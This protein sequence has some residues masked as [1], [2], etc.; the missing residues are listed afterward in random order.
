M[1]TLA[2]I[3]LMAGLVIGGV[4]LLP[5]KKKIINKIMMVKLEISPKSLPP[6][7]FTQSKTGK[8]CTY[9]S[10]RALSSWM[11]WVCKRLN[12]SDTVAV[13]FWRYNSAPLKNCYTELKVNAIT[14]TKNAINNKMATVRASHLGNENLCRKNSAICTKMV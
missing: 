6:K 4:F 2:N 5:N 10:M 12:K 8:S 3:S 7:F 9:P 11:P 1:D 14:P 13:K